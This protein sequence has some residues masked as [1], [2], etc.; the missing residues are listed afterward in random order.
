MEM[1]GP[2]TLGRFVFVL[3]GSGLPGNAGAHAGCVGHDLDE[4]FG[5]G[6]VPAGGFP[7]EREQGSAHEVL[8]ELVQLEPP[9]CHE[10][11]VALAGLLDETLPVRVEHRD[12]AAR[13]RHRQRGTGV[14]PLLTGDRALERRK[15]G[16]PP[17]QGGLERLLDLVRGSR[18]HGYTP[19]K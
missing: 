7:A 5:A 11:E 15:F 14:V 8:V 3:V 2:V 9:A 13:Q 12:T 18:C 10:V 19:K 6:G 1:S 4:R 16:A 17:E